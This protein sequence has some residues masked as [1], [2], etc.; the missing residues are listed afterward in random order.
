MYELLVDGD[1][2]FLNRAYISKPPTV[3]LAARFIPF[4]SLLSTPT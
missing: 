4:R 2:N 3:S 1:R